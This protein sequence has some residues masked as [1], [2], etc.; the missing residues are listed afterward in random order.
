MSTFQ[1]Y[2]RFHLIVALSAAVVALVLFIFPATSAGY[3]AGFS[4]VEPV[5]WMAV[6][7]VT[8]VHSTS[9]LVQFGKEA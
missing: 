3:L 9:V 5:I 8:L 6:S 7:L 2:A 4:I 1:K